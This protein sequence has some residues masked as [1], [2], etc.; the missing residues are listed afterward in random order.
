MY[1]ASLYTESLPSLGHD[2]NSL[3]T[4]VLGECQQ[5]PLEDHELWNQI[6]YSTL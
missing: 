4:T 3:K 5:K 6:F 1:A 2:Q